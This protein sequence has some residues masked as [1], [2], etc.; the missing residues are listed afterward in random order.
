MPPRLELPQGT[1]DLLILRCVANEPKPAGPSPSAFSKSQ[2]TCC[3]C[4]KVRSTRRSI[5]SNGAAGSPPNGA[6]PKTIAAQSFTHSRARARNGSKPNAMHGKHSPRGRPSVRPPRRTRC[7]TT[8]FTGCVPFSSRKSRSR[9]GRGTSLP[10]RKPNPKTPRQ[11]LN[12]RGGNAKGTTSRRRRRATERRMPRRSRRAIPRKFSSRSTLFPPD[13]AK[14]PG[15]TRRRRTDTRARHR[16]QHRNLQRYRSVLLSPIPYPDPDAS[17]PSS[18]TTRC[19]TSTTFSSKRK[20]SR[21]AAASRRSGWTYTGGPEPLQIRAAYVNAGLLETLGV[22][23]MSAVSSRPTEDVK[24]GPHNMVITHRFWREFLGADPNVLGRSLTLNGKRYIVIGVMP[25]NFALPE[26][27]TDIF[28]SL[29]VAYPEAAPFA[30]FISCGRTGASIPASHSTSA[31]RPLGH[32]RT[33][34]KAIS[35]HRGQSPKN[36]GAAPSIS[37]GRHTPRASRTPRRSRPCVPR[38]LAPTSPAC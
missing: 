13:A 30:A 12:A 16:R 24:G 34:R 35:R 4:S 37:C 27:E 2:R 26:D 18:K 28:V 3:A 10:L 36:S 19:E 38:S 6:H 23:P 29:W 11:G 25:A 15:F 1:L 9:N 32:R 7:S 31:S 22:S 17:S 14:S 5:A 20:R 33:P 8:C 21:T